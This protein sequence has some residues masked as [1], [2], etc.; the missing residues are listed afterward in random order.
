MSEDMRYRLQKM[1]W[2]RFM[3]CVFGLGYTKKAPLGEGH[4]IWREFLDRNEIVSV[5]C[6]AKRHEGE[7]FVSVASPTYGSLRVPY[8]LAMKIL[9]FDRF[10]H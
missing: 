8:D 6:E 5:P 10:P 2:D 3:R 7:S 9:V 1:V 4:R